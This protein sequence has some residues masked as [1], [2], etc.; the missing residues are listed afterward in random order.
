MNTTDNTATTTTETVSDLNAA[1]IAAT[2]AADNLKSTTIRPGLLVQLK[3]TVTGGV[4]YKRIEL[5]ASGEPAEP[6]AVVARWETTRTI[7]DPKEHEAA[8][9]IRSRALGEIRKV[10]QATSFGLLCPSDQEGALRV[11]VKRARA[12]VAGHNDA[13]THTNVKIYIITGRVAADDVEATASITSE[14]SEL[15]QAMNDGITNV[16]AKA[17]RDAATRAREL[18]AMLDDRVKSKVEG[19]IE[20]ARKA[21]RTITK[22]IEKAGEDAKL[23]LLDVQRSQIESA[24]IAFLDLTAEA[25]ATAEAASAALPAIDMQRMADLDLSDE[26]SGEIEPV[27]PAPTSGPALDL[28][29][30]S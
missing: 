9:K 3:S 22:R 1:A 20:Q 23:V 16:D 26:D 29:G 17:I 25:N 18:T 12:M 8:T 30:V 27:K 10:C 7:E 28:S 14:V 15:I 4:T 5:D 2:D 19:A 13:A 21:A 11:A 24:R 6:G